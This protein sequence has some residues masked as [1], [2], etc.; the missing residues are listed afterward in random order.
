MNIHVYLLVLLLAQGA[1][2]LELVFLNLKP[3]LK[4]GP[5]LAKYVINESQ[6]GVAHTCNAAFRS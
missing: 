4:C 1:P 6:T 3:Q 2:G 5:D